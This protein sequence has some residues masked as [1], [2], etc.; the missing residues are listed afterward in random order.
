MTEVSVRPPRL[1]ARRRRA[2]W[3]DYA[4][5]R[6]TDPELFFPAGTAG[7]AL[8]QAEQAKLVCAACP[9]RRPCLDWAMASGQEAG[10]WGGTTEEERRALRSQRR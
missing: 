10:V 7:P 2:H 4:A 3:R 1:A 9:V 8:V 6:D 5:C